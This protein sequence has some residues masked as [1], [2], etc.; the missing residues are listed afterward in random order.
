MWQKEAGYLRN[1]ENSRVVPDGQVINFLP[2][3]TMILDE[4]ESEF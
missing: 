1:I 3:L 4:S 2:Y